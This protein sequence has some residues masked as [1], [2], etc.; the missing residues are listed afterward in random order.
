M[1]EHPNAALVRRLNEAWHAGDVETVREILAED[2]VW[3]E[4]GTH[5]YSGELHGLAGI[6][7]LNAHV[8]RVTGGAISIETHDYLGS[9]DHAV[10]LQ[11]V[12]AERDGETYRIDEVLT[13]HV[14]DGR[15]TS[16]YVTYSDLARA[17]RLL[18]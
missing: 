6:M 1:T 5:P 11:R 13:C 8:A 7:Q 4:P 2:V 16:I 9:D 14:H 17:E 3:H 12:T 10:I 15:V 18:A